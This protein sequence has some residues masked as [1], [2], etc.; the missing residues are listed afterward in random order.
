[1]V[2]WIKIT[3]P[4]R[5]KNKPNHPAFKAEFESYVEEVCD[6]SCFFYDAL[7]CYNGFFG[8]IED[9]D[10]ETIY[11]LAQRVGYKL[12]QKEIK[13]CKKQF[14]KKLIETYVPK[15][16]QFLLSLYSKKELF[17][18]DYES[19]IRTSSV[20]VQNINLLREWVT[21]GDS[22]SGYLSSYMSLFE[23]VIYP[24]YSLFLKRLSA[25]DR[26][27][28]NTKHLK[29]LSGINIDKKAG[30]LTNIESFKNLLNLIDAS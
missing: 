25:S 11:E 16:Q 20:I 26:D 18:G 9:F 19:D 30:I 22:Q 23:S 14:K 10:R 28:L 7:K 15:T 24:K 13:L 17:Q 3:F 4:F 21:D 27:K 1:M 6:Y 12:N 5:I 29:I 2:F 8:L